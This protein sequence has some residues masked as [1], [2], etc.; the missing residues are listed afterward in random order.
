MGGAQVYV[1]NK[2]DYLKKN[3]WNVD[4]YTGRNGFPVIN[5][6]N[7]YAGNFY[8]EL[9][10]YPF[11]TSIR[12]KNEILDRI[13]GEYDSYSQIIVESNKLPY[14]VW[15]EIAAQKMNAKHLFFCLDEE[16]N[17]NCMDWEYAF[18]NYMH[19]RKSLAGIEHSSLKRMFKDYKAVS[20]EEAYSLYASDENIQADIVYE[21]QLPDKDENTVCIGF[22][23]RLDKSNVITV[24]DEIIRYAEELQEVNVVF[25][26]IGD[27]PDTSLKKEIK[28]R[29]DG[30]N[31][32]IAILTGF[33]YP[34][35]KK[36]MDY[37]DVFVCSSGAALATAMVG[38]I[39]V[40]TDVVYGK[41][42]GIMGYDLMPD[43]SV[44]A[45]PNK[46]YP[47]LSQVLGDLV[48]RSKREEIE[49]IISEKYH[50]P[51]SDYMKEFDNHMNFINNS[52]FSDGY[53]DFTEIEW[54]ERTGYMLAKDERIINIY[55]KWMKLKADNI[56]I[57]ALLIDRGY[58]RICLYGL[59]HLGRS[60]LAELGNSK[61]E[62]SEIVD[63][64]VSKTDDGT[65]VHPGIS[66][67]IG[68]DAVLV[69][70]V[71]MTGAGKCQLRG[72]Y[73]NNCDVIWLE[74]LIGS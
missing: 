4:I 7:E 36:I 73:P 41:A 19:K 43:A 44:F 32:L 49:K 1:H 28:Q 25:I 21:E 8:P 70:T 11:H 47:P 63:G 57:S 13:C 53:Y 9:N 69:T 50:N 74:D 37:V 31:N 62:I 72:K 55:D 10:E 30:I 2:L 56:S 52:D 33:L 14:A 42:L 24:I 71:D 29:L 18:L 26:L 46:E 23:S 51:S 35:P 5:E 45:D 65:E 38:K 66:D 68:V 16:F 64:Y 34:V 6:M 27:A 48:S 3:G 39:T 67:D 12:R 58:Q 22:I 54:K 15:G 60:V 40:T 61:I 59:G 17:P 20:D